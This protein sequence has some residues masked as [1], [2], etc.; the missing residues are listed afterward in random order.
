MIYCSQLALFISRWGNL[1]KAKV[2]NFCTKDKYLLI[3]IIECFN[4]KMLG[5]MLNSFCI[6]SI[7]KYFMCEVWKLHHTQCQ[8]NI[9]NLRNI[10]KKFLTW[11][12]GNIST[13]ANCTFKKKIKSYVKHSSN[14]GHASDFYRR[15]SNQIVTCYRIIFSHHLPYT[16]N[17]EN[18]MLLLV[19]YTKYN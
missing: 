6:I 11:G 19:L 8:R 18:I 7:D 4:D 9:R 12:G 15:F 14:V 10:M 16:Y 17:S 5:K 13:S 2:Y 3:I 1:H